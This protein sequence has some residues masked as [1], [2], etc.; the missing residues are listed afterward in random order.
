ME[1][2]EMDTTFN[3]KS[4]HSVSNWDKCSHFLGQVI[5]ACATLG[6]A[7]VVAY[8]TFKK[9]KTINSDQQDSMEICNVQ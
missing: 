9:A 6:A 3:I 8:A 1:I 7:G 2:H 4:E 5:T